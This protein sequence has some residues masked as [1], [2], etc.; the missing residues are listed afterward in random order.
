[1]PKILQVVP[2]VFIVVLCESVL[3]FKGCKFLPLSALASF[4]FEVSTHFS[5]NL[6]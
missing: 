6:R 2:E 1:M 4:L 5:F 3:K